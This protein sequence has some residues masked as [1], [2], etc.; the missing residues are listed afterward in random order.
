MAPLAGY[1][2]LVVLVLV[3]SAQ[4][5]VY[6]QFEERLEVFITR[7]VEEE[8]CSVYRELLR[9]PLP[10][11]HHPPPAPAPHPNSPPPQAALRGLRAL[12]RGGDYQG[13]GHVMQ[14]S[15]P[16]YKILQSSRLNLPKVRH[17]NGHGDGIDFNLSLIHI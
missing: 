17:I 11:E 13:G 8:G 3:A 5:D 4:E 16:Q 7:T 2:W 1:W 10:P 14:K 6:Q 12:L 15:L 9:S